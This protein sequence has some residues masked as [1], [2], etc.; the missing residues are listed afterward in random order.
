[1][2]KGV[3]MFAEFPPTSNAKNQAASLSLT[4]EIYPQRLGGRLGRVGY[5]PPRT[6]IS[7]D[8][9]AGDGMLPDNR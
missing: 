8:P 7:I 4:P 1:M 5:S 3:P 6:I 2:A 9:H